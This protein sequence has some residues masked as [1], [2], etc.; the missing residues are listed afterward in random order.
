MPNIILNY[1]KYMLMAIKQAKKAFSIGEVPIGAIVVHKNG[2]VIGRG[3]NKMEKMNCQ[4]G[5][6]EVTAIQKAC[7]KIGDWRLSNC[8]M[9]VT[10][11][12]CLMCFGLIKLSRIKKVVYGTKSPMFGFSKINNK[13]LPLVKKDLP[14]FKP[15]V[16]SGIKK[17]ECSGLLKTFFK[18][19]RK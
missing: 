13:N 1:D 3:Y 9:Y 4:I 12:P 10:L 7:K 16:I 5:H 14:I 6:A 18:N 8:S 2:E 17:D 19:V 15:H 11:E